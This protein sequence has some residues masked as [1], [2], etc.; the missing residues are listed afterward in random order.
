MDLPTRTKISIHIVDQ[1]KEFGALAGIA[2]TS[3]L[4]ES[5]SY[6]SYEKALVHQ[7]SKLVWP[8]EAKSVL[9]LALHHPKS[10]PELDWWGRIPG[11]TIGNY[12]LIN[13]GQNLEQ[14][15]NKESEKIWGV[16]INA[17]L[18]PYQ[19]KEGGVFL[20]DAA[21]MAGLGVIGK[22]NLLIT[23]EFGPRVRLKALFL[24]ADLKATG[25]ID[26]NSKHSF[27]PCKS[28][29]M[30][31]KSACPQKAFESGSYNMPPC[32]NEMTKNEANSV[33]TADWLNDGKSYRIIQYC[34]ACELACPVPL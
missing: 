1:A 28:C 33:V 25:P 3:L 27:N 5:P 6:A 34:R 19:V 26:T 20:K 32:N 17:R 18:L 30:P 9:V 29:H 31:C 2:S 10:K 11:K 23:P 12:Q 15:L 14:W 4:K 24:D 21:V 7:E 13:V 8:V 22:N 16:Q